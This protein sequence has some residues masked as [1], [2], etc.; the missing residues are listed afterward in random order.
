MA[1]V[2]E[3][4]RVTQRCTVAVAVAAVALAALLPAQAAPAHAGSAPAFT[5]ELLDGKTL[6]LADYKGSAV[7][8]L[9]WA[10]W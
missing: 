9:F 7:I 4:R 3:M 8:L 2:R 5:L 10:P 6:R 1:G